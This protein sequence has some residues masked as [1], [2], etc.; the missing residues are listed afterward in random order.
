M[1]PI[2]HLAEVSIAAD[3]YQFEGPDNVTSLKAWA[4]DGVIS[5]ADETLQ[6]L[7]C[8]QVGICTTTDSAES[9]ALSYKTGFKDLVC[10]V[11]LILESSL[12]DDELQRCL[13]WID[14]G[15]LAVGDHRA[16]WVNLISKYPDYAA[17]LVESRAGDDWIDRCIKVRDVKR[18][19]ATATIPSANSMAW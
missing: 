17:D 19:A 12:K 8:Y 10:G 3:K 18:N 11:D 4:V 7:C 9:Q 6:R 1:R 13:T 2:S 5:S 16:A 15:I 14:W